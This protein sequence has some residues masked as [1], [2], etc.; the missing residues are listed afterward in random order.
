MTWG[1][2]WGFPWGTGSCEL[3]PQLTSGSWTY[4]GTYRFPLNPVT[5]VLTNASQSLIR[6]NMTGSTPPSD[7]GAAILNVIAVS[8]SSRIELWARPTYGTSS[9]DIALNLVL[10]GADIFDGNQWS[11]SV[12]RFRHDDPTDYLPSGSFKSD[13]SASYFLRAARADRGF[14][15]EVYTTQ[16]FFLE[17]HENDPDQIIW[18]QT[19]SLL[20]PSGVYFT[21]GNETLSTDSLCLHTS[22]V[23]D[24]AR[25]TS[26]DGRVT[27]MRFWSQGLLTEEWKEHVRN[28][29]SLGVK[30]PLVGFNF[31]TTRTGSFGKLRID[32]ST[33]QEITASD[34][35]GEII[36]FDYSQHN[37]HLTGS[38][39]EVSKDV[40]KPETFYY[41]LISP[42][43]DEAVTSNKVRA[44]GFLDLD[45]ANEHGVA[46]GPVYEINPNEQPEDDTRF[47][48]DFSI[49]D[50]LDQD[51]INIFSTLEQLDNALGAP[52]VMFS[53]DYQGLEQLRDVYFQRLTG[54]INLKS[55]FEFFK[56]FDRSIGHFIEA[57]VPRKTKFRG[58][59]F[60]VE[61]HMLERG[62]YQHQN[63][64]MYL[65]AAERHS[66]KGTIL[67]QQLVAII[68]RY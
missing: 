52:E 23:P 16:S 39:F 6:F 2:E 20:N 17:D 45:R 44:R 50:A 59:N 67:L 15:Q 37:Y 12:G 7:T 58:V 30:D 46:F 1:C 53:Y 35:A 57:L 65:N 64:D 11:V 24:I 62:K 25:T 4:E 22:S 21:I 38:G 60:V 43:F 51:I 19:G 5:G 3:L 47:N 29:K 31:V 8:A 9:A 18:Q 61:S 28:F 32:A 63:M 13:S 48:I 14:I 68:N 54:K 10:T 34:S 49:V 40:V 55:F 41:G 27:Q 33:D 26:F 66:L 36:L 56:W 42:R